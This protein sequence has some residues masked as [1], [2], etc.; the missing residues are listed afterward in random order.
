MADTP[1]FS[2]VIPTYNRCEPLKEA[3][4]SVIDQ[5]FESWELLVVDDGSKDATEEVVKAYEQKDP[6]VRYIYQENAERCAARNNGIDKS[7]GRY[8][9][10]L[11]SDDVYLKHHLSSFKKELEIRSN[12]VIML[13]GDPISEVDGVRIKE[14]PY[15]TITGHP[16]ETFIKSAVPSQTTCLHHDILMKYKYDLNFKIGEDIELFCR[17]ANEFPIEHIHSHTA[18]IRDFGDRTI[19]SRDMRVYT[20]SI[21]VL[22]HIWKVRKGDLIQREWYKFGLSSVKYKQALQHLR[23]GEKFAYVYNVLVSIAIYPSHFFKDKVKGL[24]TFKVPEAK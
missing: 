18:V 20:E 10:F 1:F 13:F 21:R 17:I 23:R 9:C 14:I 5:D 12:P 8:I 16:V 22:K 6:R 11:D 24:I 7:N 15:K 19:D 4:Q 3:I 2:I